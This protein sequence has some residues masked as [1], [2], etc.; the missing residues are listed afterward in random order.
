MTEYEYDSDDVNTCPA[1]GRVLGEQEWNGECGDCEQLTC[2]CANKS[3]DEQVYIEGSRCEKC[4]KI[5]L[6]ADIEQKY[7]GAK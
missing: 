3:C 7:G 1:C 4:E 5:A 6:D 2:P